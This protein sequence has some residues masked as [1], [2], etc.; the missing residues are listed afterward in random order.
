MLD[1]PI[2]RDTDFPTTAMCMA[3]ISLWNRSEMP[4]NRSLDLHI[5]LSAGSTLTSE[6]FATDSM[7]AACH[8]TTLLVSQLR[9]HD[10]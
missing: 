8:T 2:P 9:S 3:A 4:C 1:L 7:C 5:Q 10:L 6:T